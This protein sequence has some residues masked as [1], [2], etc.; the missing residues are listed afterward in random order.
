MPVGWDEATVKGDEAAAA[1]VREAVAI[2]TASLGA[3]MATRPS[4]PADQTPPE[5]A[6]YFVDPP[7]LH[8]A[9]G[10][11][12]SAGAAEHEAAQVSWR[13]CQGLPSASCTAACRCHA[14]GCSSV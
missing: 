9:P 10:A 13:S 7:L 8:A 2:A 5:A 3:I 14:E 6:Y 12:A 1:P 4:Q 11:E